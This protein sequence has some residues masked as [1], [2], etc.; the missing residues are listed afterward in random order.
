MLLE[1]GGQETELF[2]AVDGHAETSIDPGRVRSG[3]H[4]IRHRHFPLGGASRRVELS[5]EERPEQ[6]YQPGSERQEWPKRQGRGR[7]HPDPAETQAAGRDE[8]RGRGAEHHLR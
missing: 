3:G 7:A 1:L 8:R 6:P 4:P 2:Q 5:R